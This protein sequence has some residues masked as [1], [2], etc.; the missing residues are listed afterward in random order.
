MV[1]VILALACR[2]VDHGDH[3]EPVAEFRR[4]AG[5]VRKSLHDLLRTLG[6]YSAMVEESFQNHRKEKAKRSTSHD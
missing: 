3:G 5:K 4:E 1:R 6:Y 2:D